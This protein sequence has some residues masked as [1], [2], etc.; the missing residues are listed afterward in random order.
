[1]A[2]DA[3]SVLKY[4]VDLGHADLEGVPGQ[5]RLGARPDRQGHLPPG[6]H[7]A[8]R[9]DP[10]DARHPGR[11]GLLDVP[12]PGQHRHG[13][14][15]ADRGPGRGARLP[16]ARRPRRL[17]RHRQRAELPDAG[18]EVVSRPV[19]VRRPHFLD[20]DGLAPALPRRRARATRSSWSTATRRGR[21]T[22]AIWSRAL[23]D[24]YRC[25][26][27]DHIG[28]GL[29]DKPQPPRYD[30]SLESRVDDLTALLDHLGVRRERHAGAA[31]LGRDDRHG[32]GRPAPR[33]RSSDWWS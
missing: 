17:P 33:A 29:S 8:P 19:S 3:G 21:S 4:G 6:R 10:E 20:R 27:P 24:R 15:A 16:A 22:T 13:V 1:M 32:L 2:T 12:V 26:V 23:R 30:Y 7:A 5:A 9:H 25:I 31:R 11:Q 28:C 18:G 14:A